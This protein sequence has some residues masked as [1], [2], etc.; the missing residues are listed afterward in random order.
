[1][2]TN[3]ICCITKTASCPAF[4]D[5]AIKEGCKLAWS[6]VKRGDVVLFDFNHNGTSDHIG[7]V[8]KVGDNCVYTIEGNTGAGSNT[9]GG[10]VQRRV[11][12]KNQVNYFVRPKYNMY[13]T[14]EMALAAALCEVGMSE[15]PANSNKVKYNQWFY[16]SNTAAYWC[17]TF[18]CWVF[19]HMKEK[20]RSTYS[21][22]ISTQTL[23][24][25]SKGEPVKMLQEFLNWY[26]SAGIKVD[27]DFGSTTEQYVMAFQALESLTID[28]VFGAKSISSASM[29]SGVRETNYTENGRTIIGTLTASK[30]LELPTSYIGQSLAI[31]SSGERA[32]F[33]SLRSGAEQM[34]TTY[35]NDDKVERV[36]T[37]GL[38]HANGAT[39]NPDKDRYYVCSYYGSG[40]TKKITTINAKT[41]KK[42][43][44]FNLSVAVSGIAYDRIR[45][46]YVGSKG[47]RIYIFSNNLKKTG[48]FRLK[49][50]G[51][52]AQDIFAHNGMIYVC[53]SYV[54]GKLSYIDVYNYSGSYEGSYKCT[55]NELES[56]DIDENGYIHYITWNAARLIKTKVKVSQ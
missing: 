18:V 4:G 54:S 32:V 12:Y 3:G 9:N 31:K 49:L 28:G 6:Q 44:S 26:L 27:G 42:I 37:T 50:T 36:K 2:T 55:A 14:K 11:R 48:T 1:M 23:A 16:G 30:T 35:S 24:K 56:A 46:Q 13:M 20:P 52:T 39:Y 17:C 15:S 19:A 51:G 41:L 43:E 5:W 7:I 53:R 10:Q 47:T 38:G 25:G 21:G 8:Y 45:K 34:I 40:N 22:E 29:Y 33:S